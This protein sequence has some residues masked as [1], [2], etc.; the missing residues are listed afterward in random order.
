[1]NVNKKKS[2][3][4]RLRFFTWRFFI[5]ILRI[6]NRRYTPLND[7]LFIFTDCDL[8]AKIL[9]GPWTPSKID[10]LEFITSSGCRVM[11]VFHTTSIA[12]KKGIY[13][14]IEQR[15]FAPLAT[16]LSCS[17]KYEWEYI[18]YWDCCAHLVQPSIDMVHSAVFDHG[19][20]I[21]TVCLLL[22]HGLRVRD[23]EY[24]DSQLWIWTETAGAK[25]VWLVWL[26]SNLWRVK[27]VAYLGDY[28]D[29]ARARRITQRYPDV[30][31]L[32][33][34][35]DFEPDVIVDRVRSEFSG[36]LDMVIKD[37]RRHVSQAMP[38]RR[39]V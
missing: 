9:H 3:L 29:A 39:T 2:Q 36:L 13:D 4:L 18:N 24:L 32:D 27:N 20:S 10:F 38:Q 6:A 1:M 15:V 23:F 8:P 21:G 35:G 14:A 25:G 12:A 30:L 11:D 19:C 22:I 31:R 37:I 28:D 7:E 26:L 33:G 16:L 34:M 5:E 17:F